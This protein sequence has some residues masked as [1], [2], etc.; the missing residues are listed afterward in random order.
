MGTVLY[1]DFVAISAPQPFIFGSTSTT[2]LLKTVEDFSGDVVLGTEVVNASNLNASTE[3]LCHDRL[4]VCPI[5]LSADTVIDG[6]VY[7]SVGVKLWTNVP[8]A[9]V[10]LTKIYA[11]IVKISSSG[12]QTSLSGGDYL[13]WSGV[14]FLEEKESSNIPATRTK[15]FPF[16][17]Y[18]DG[19][20]VGRN[21]RI[22]LRIKIYGYATQNYVS[23][24][25]NRIYLAYN[26][27]TKQ[28]FM[29]LPIA[30]SLD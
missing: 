11:N 7:G 1:K 21:E 9:G 15:I 18:I 25:W 23:P 28:T 29:S 3:A 19:Q 30:V 4:Y 10:A 27:N 22:G 13:V 17:S 5:P 20:T 8:S 24:S 6:P 26:H 14:E 2:Q 16:W 12:A